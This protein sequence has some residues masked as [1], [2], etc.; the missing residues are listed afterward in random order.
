MRPSSS[1][2][3]P[4]SPTTTWACPA[5]TPFATRPLLSSRQKQLDPDAPVRK[6]L[7][8]VF[9]TRNQHAEVI[10]RPLRPPVRAEAVMLR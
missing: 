3:T 2:R 5:N 4:P 8:L 10:E 6:N 7:A 9:E 1:G